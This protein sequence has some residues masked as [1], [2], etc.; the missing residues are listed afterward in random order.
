MP[1]V[2]TIGGRRWRVLEWGADGFILEGGVPQASPGDSYD[3]TLQLTFDA[4]QLAFDLIATAS[5]VVDGK[6]CEFVFVALKP[7]HASTIEHIVDRWLAGES[8]PLGGGATNSVSAEPAASES[9]R[10]G[11]RGGYSQLYRLTA[12]LV[13]CL[14]ILGAL[15]TAAIHRLLTVTSQYAAVAAD[16]T[17]VRA[18]QDGIFADA[19][20]AAGQRVKNGT[21]L[22]Y[23]HPAVSPQEREAVAAQAAMAAAR[24]TQE[25]SALADAESG[26]RNFQTV[27][28][29]SYRSAKDERVALDREIETQMSIVGRYR[30]L[31]RDGYVA[32]LQADQQEQTLRDLERQRAV[33]AANEEAARQSFANAGRGIYGAD[34]HSAQRTPAQIQATIAELEAQS[35]Q[36]AQQ[37]SIMDTNLPINAPCDCMVMAAHAAD[38]QFV[39]K[40]G[41]I[42]DLGSQN[43]AQLE[44]DALVPASAANAL[45]IGEEARVLLADRRNVITGHIARINLNATNTG[46]IG[47]PDALRSLDLYALVTV[48]MDAPSSLASA[49]PAGTP[50][51]V[52]FPL[53]LSAVARSFLGLSGR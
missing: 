50:A 22:G 35:H 25:R 36:L 40:N 37:L 43:D 20:V 33:A 39:A 18:V 45:H 14:L 3:V 7:E 48:S 51:T 21:L 10:T 4:F 17:Q 26:F 2:V 34:G 9:R 42:L 46:R 16:L 6:A 13:I 47:L 28:S 15:A 38:G 49:E 41:P 53:R 32:Q 44:V 11:R 19:R 24:L 30:E 52:D 8:T 29:T 27:A 12:G 31:A 5:R 23:L 1:A